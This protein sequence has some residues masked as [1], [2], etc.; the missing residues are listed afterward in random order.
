MLQADATICPVF[1]T[2]LEAPPPSSAGSNGLKS[3]DVPLWSFFFFHRHTFP[4]LKKEKRE[5]RFQW[6]APEIRRFQVDII[7]FSLPLM[8]HNNIECLYVLNWL[9]SGCFCCYLLSF[10]YWNLS[11]ADIPWLIRHYF[12]FL[13]FFHRKIPAHVAIDPYI[14]LW[15]DTYWR[16]EPFEKER[17]PTRRFLFLFQVDICFLDKLHM[18]W[19]RETFSRRIVSIEMSSFKLYKLRPERE[20]K[21]YKVAFLVH[22]QLGLV[23]T[24]WKRKKKGCGVW[25]WWFCSLPTQ[26]HT[27]RTFFF[28]KRPI[29]ICGK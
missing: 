10:T 21:E 11:T 25:V 5:S 17:S 24:R 2:K 8:Y 4:R 6:S 12:F 28:Q 29:S 14:G 9:P 7:F 18:G 13:F 15:G 26:T 23:H 19:R 20:K 3:I 16:P 27:T 22:V 1:H